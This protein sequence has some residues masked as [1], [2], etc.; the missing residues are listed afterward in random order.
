MITIWNLLAQIIKKVLKQIIS[1][2][3]RGHILATASSSYLGISIVV[4]SFCF[5]IYVSNSIHIYHFSSPQVLFLG[6]V[7][8]ICETVARNSELYSKIYEIFL[9]SLVSIIYRSLLLLN[10]SHRS[11]WTTLTTSILNK[12]TTRFLI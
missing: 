1:F 10:L 5:I 11:S 7:R 4:I 9:R 6:N 8:D 3:I 12:I 2:F